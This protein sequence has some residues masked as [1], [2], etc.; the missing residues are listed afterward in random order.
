MGVKAFGNTSFFGSQQPSNLGHNPQEEI[1]QA[2]KKIQFLWRQTHLKQTAKESSKYVNRIVSLKKAQ[3]QSFTELEEFLRD[4][5]IQ[6][7]THKLLLHLEQAKTLVIPDR[8]Q[9]PAFQVSERIFLSAYLIATKPDHIIE[10][11]TELDHRII[12]NAGE[13]LVAFEKLCKFMSQTYLPAPPARVSSP[14][15]RETPSSDN[16]FA[17]MEQLHIEQTNERMQKDHRFLAEGRPYLENFHKAQMAYYAIFAD[18]ELHNST[19]LV[20]I[21]IAKYLHI[22]SRHFEALNNLDPR[23]LEWCEAFRQQQKVLREKIKELK[24]E[25]GLFMLEE[26]LKAHQQMLEANKWTLAPPDVLM[27]EMAL[28]PHFTLTES[29]SLIL[30]ENDVSQAIGAL[31]LENVEPILTVLEEIRDHISYLVPHNQQFIANL[32]EEFNREGIGALIREVGIEDALYK[33]IFAL[34]EKIK[35][36]ESPAHLPET[37]AFLKE[38]DFKLSLQGTD[39]NLI[40]KTAIEFIYKKLSEINR[41]LG[42][43]YINQSRLSVSHNIETFEQS[44]F[45]ERLGKKQFNLANVLESLNQIVVSPEKFQL[46]TAALCS[47]HVASHVARAILLSTLQHNGQLEASALPE[48]FYLDHKRLIQWHRRFQQLFYTGSM[49]AF[50]ETAA[51][52]LG[53][54][55]PPS[56]IIEQKET[57]LRLL[58]A[59]ELDTPEKVA[60]FA[61][62]SLMIVLAKQGKIISPRE[63]S[64]FRT[65]AGNIC[66][67]NHKAAEIIRN[68]LSN[69]LSMFLSKG[70]FP[71]QVQGKSKVYGLES[72]IAK[73]GDDILPV[74]H[75]HLKVHGKFYRKRMEARLWE[76]LYKIFREPHPPSDIPSMVA[77][78]EESI[79]ATH[80]YIQKLSFMLSGLILIQQRIFHEN[81][82]ELGLM[83]DPS[84]LKEHAVTKDIIKM[85]NDPSISLDTIENKL[86]ELMKK[87]AAEHNITYEADDERKM[88]RMFSLAKTAQT[89]GSKVVLAELTTVCRKAAKGPLPKINHELISLFPD[90]IK[91]MCDQVNKIMEDVKEYHTVA[92]S[93]PLAQQIPMMRSGKTLGL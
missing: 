66:T 21:F 36:L 13:M 57:L 80:A 69:H 68:R 70:Y 28:N 4:P 23:E 77:I 6:T 3:A 27:H 61:T 43:Y 46:T 52:Q 35:L 44:R 92:D 20:K 72:E 18:W 38:L 88:A 81:A 59:G 9:L 89:P 90:E 55:I 40:L 26:E 8:E 53:T 19:R 74:L 45:K 24:G 39:R 5:S 51:L 56:E 54:K 33:V 76:P 75:L 29:D 63:E 42:N 83:L 64:L 93:E 12:Q 58:D 67:G 84:T 30:P 41:D 37:Q 86:L 14:M 16:V 91:K 85:V 17:S 25:E 7:L 22:E 62:T 78:E 34:F 47:K 71:E 32:W 15:A 49:L 60:D 11:P 1:L 2:A 48:T 79:V 10:D 50:M 87:V 31:E 65:L 82:W 73:L